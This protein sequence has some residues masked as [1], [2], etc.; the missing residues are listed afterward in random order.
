MLVAEET[1]SYLF[2]KLGLD[3]AECFDEF[4]R[5]KM[6]LIYL[7]TP[8]CAVINGRRMKHTGFGLLKRISP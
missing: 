2:E 7:T 8:S 4:G 5:V 3:I 1:S 6:N